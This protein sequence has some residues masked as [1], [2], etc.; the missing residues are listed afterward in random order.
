[1][2]HSPLDQQEGSLSTPS[3]RLRVKVDLAAPSLGTPGRILLQHPR[4]RELVPRFL[5]AGY[6]VARSMVPLMEAALGRARDLGPDDRV[7]AQLVPYLER[8]IPEEMHGDAPGEAALADLAALGVDV[9]RLRASLPAPKIAALVGATYY[10]I[11][12]HHFW[13][14]GHAN[15]GLTALAALATETERS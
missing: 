3:G 13:Y 15:A 4:A 10:W 12:E 14:D 2:L 1:M 11:V 5:A 9:A 8:H 7:A 6:Q